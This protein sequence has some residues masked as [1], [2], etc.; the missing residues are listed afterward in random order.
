[1]FCCRLLYLHSSF[2]IILIGKRALVA[3]LDLS[4]WCL[5]IFAWL[6]LVVA[7]VSLQFMIVVFPG[8]THILYSINYITFK[9]F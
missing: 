6:F 2:A 4:S 9:L 7:W 8:H 5:V 3:L 1:M